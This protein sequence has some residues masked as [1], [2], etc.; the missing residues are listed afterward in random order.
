[1]SEKEQVT[2][3]CILWEGNAVDSFEVAR[4]KSSVGQCVDV[5]KKDVRL[6]RSAQ[7]MV[8]GKHTQRRHCSFKVHLP[9]FVMLVV[10]ECLV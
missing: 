6:V 4:A 8:F 9:N 1:M 3:E 5:Y 10:F 2:R 7:E